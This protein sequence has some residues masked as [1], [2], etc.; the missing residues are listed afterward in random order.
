MTLATDP[1]SSDDGWGRPTCRDSHPTGLHTSLPSLGRSGRSAKS[2]LVKRVVRH[3]VAVEAPRSRQSR[4][5]RV[6]LS[7]LA[8]SV[9]SSA[10]TAPDERPGLV[11]VAAL[12]SEGSCFPSIG[13]GYLRFGRD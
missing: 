10:T 9:A 5:G 1:W 8:G 3:V 11:I 7:S 4:R 6:L 12:A 2:N 13:F